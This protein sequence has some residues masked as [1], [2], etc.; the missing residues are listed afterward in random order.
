[1]FSDPN[2]QAH[3][4]GV[5]EPEVYREVLERAARYQLPYNCRNT[6]AIVT[7]TQLMTG[8]DVGVAKAGQG[9]VVQFDRPLTDQDLASLLDARLKRLRREEID[10]SDVVVITLR[11]AVEESSATGTKAFAR[12]QLVTVTDNRAPAESGVARLVT[13]MTFKGLEASHVLVVDV[14]DVSTQQGMSRL[15]VAMTRPRISLWL[16]VGPLAWRQLAQAPRGDAHD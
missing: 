15:Y 2:N 6:S 1:M 11:D 3:I 4:D 5:F 16:A 13:A 10:L 8:A 9:P 7:Q 12:G 14:D